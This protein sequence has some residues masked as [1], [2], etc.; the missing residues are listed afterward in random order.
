MFLNK[1]LYLQIFN[2]RTENSIDMLKYLSLLALSLLFN[3]NTHGQEII[4]TIM[5]NNKKAILFSDRTWILIE[6]LNFDGVMNEQLN[7]AILSYDELDFNL[8]WKTDQT[9]SS[10]RS[11]D[12]SK[13]KD[14]IW[15]CVQNEEHHEFASPLKEPVRITSRYK[16]RHGRHHNGIDLDLQTGDTV[17]AVWSGKIRYSQYND[18]GFGNLVVVRHHN[19]LETFYAHLSKLIV[20][21]NQYVKAGDPI[22][23][24]GNTG[25]SYGSHLH[26]EVRFYDIPM[27]PENVIDFENGIC[28][29]E[30]LFIHKDLFRPSSYNV[31]SNYS[32]PS[33]RKY[34]R[35]RSGDTLSEIARRYSTSVS[36]LCRLN[37]IR[38][39]TVLQ[40]GRNLRVR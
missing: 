10:N 27:D 24:G 37:G 6:D 4:D 17:Y 11:N 39:T 40:I 23:L 35:I 36:N 16:Y 13:L 20:V 22:G 34:Y 15:M 8:P 29:N 3:I 9:Y 31:A 2:L 7:Q 33:S 18:G 25:N 12:I 32:S 38:Q 1:T 21:P 19:G 26:F 28:K 14:T 5:V 30:N